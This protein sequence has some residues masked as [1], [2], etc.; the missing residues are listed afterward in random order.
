MRVRSL[1]A[2]VVA[3]SALGVAACGDE[4]FENNPRPPAPISLTARIGDGGVS[5]GPQDIGAGI[6]NITISN[7]TAD[8]ATLVFEGP[9]D[10]SSDEIVAGGTGSMK[11][12]LEEGDYQVSN[13]GTGVSLLTVGPERES[14]QNELL[15]P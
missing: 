2:V 7:Q 10:E 6:A 12:T 11:V 3:L 13:G 15:L 1:A 8:P 4:D 14:S 5:V 9:T